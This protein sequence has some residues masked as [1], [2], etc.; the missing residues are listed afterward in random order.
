MPREIVDAKKCHSFFLTNVFVNVNSIFCYFLYFF[1]D[2]FVC[3]FSFVG[4]SLSRC[5]SHK[6]KKLKKKTNKCPWNHQRLIVCTELGQTACD[7]K[8]WIWLRFLEKLTFQ[9]GIAPNQ[10]S[11]CFFFTWQKKPYQRHF[12][13]EHCFGRILTFSISTSNCMRKRELH[14]YPSLYAWGHTVE[15]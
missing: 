12:T 8:T 2:S 11:I 9:K 13:L 6:Y 5:Y 3:F 10:N 7:N 4:I 14:M 15:C 1:F